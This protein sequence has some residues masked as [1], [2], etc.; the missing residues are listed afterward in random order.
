MGK[1]S[2]NLAEEEFIN[3]L[4]SQFGI[5]RLEAIDHVIE[6]KRDQMNYYRHIGNH[7]LA[8]QLKKEIGE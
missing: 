3:A 7:A 4:M 6:Y 5:T 1:V 8:D 2:F